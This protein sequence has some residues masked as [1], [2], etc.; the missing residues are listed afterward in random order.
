MSVLRTNGPLVYAFLKLFSVY[1]K[2]IDLGAM[3]WPC[4]IENSI[5]KRGVIMRLNDF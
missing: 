5:I 3:T 2:I 4:Y 1:S